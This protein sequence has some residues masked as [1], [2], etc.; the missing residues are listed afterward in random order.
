V[1]RFP[2]IHVYHRDDAP[3]LYAMVYK[4]FDFD[5]SKKYPAVLNVYGGPEVQLVVNS[6]RVC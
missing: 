3:D 4:P 5:P 6:F 1:L 2:E